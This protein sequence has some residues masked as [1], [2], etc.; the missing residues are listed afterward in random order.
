MS[1]EL[2]E[3]KILS[4][5]IKYADK[6][7]AELAEEIQQPILVEGPQGPVGP[8]GPKGEKGDTGPERR[9]VIEARGPVGPK[10]E[11][12]A[13]F[14]KALLED[15][16]LQLIREDGE[17]FVVGS[18]VGPRGGQGIPGVKGD[19]GDTGPRGE[20]GLIGEQGPV[21]AVGP[22]GDKGD[23]G[24]RGLQGERGFLGPQGP[25]GERGLIGEQGEPGPI[26]PQGIQGPKGDKGDKG[27]P[28]ATGPMGPQ[29]VP[30]RDGTEVDTESIRKSIEDNYQS[31]RDQIRQQVTRLATSGGGS[32]GGGIGPRPKETL[33]T[34]DILPQANDTYNLGG[35]GAYWKD[36]Y[37]SGNTLTL[38]AS[39]I[40][41]NNGTVSFG[42]ISAQTAPAGTSNTYV[43]TTEF[44]QV[45][46]GNLVNTAPTT[47]NTLKELADSLGNN[48]DFIGTVNINL[49]SKASN[50]Y[51]N[52][53]LSNTNSYI[54]TKLDS[55]SYTTADVQAKAALA[56][57]NA[58][59]DTKT[60]ESTSL[61]RLSN[62]NSYIATKIGNVVED[63]TPQLGGSLDVNGN[64]IVSVSNGDI[65]IE[66]NGTGNVLLGNL[67]FDAD[68]TVGAGQDNYVLTYDDA[69]GTIGLEAAAGGGG[70]GWEY[71]STITASNSSTIDFFGVFSS[72]YDYKITGQEIRGQYSNTYYYARLEMNNTGS[73]FTSSVYALGNIRTISGVTYG[74]TSSG[75]TL[76]EL[77]DGNPQGVSSASQ[78]CNFDLEIINP[79]DQANYFA[80]IRYVVWGRASNNTNFGQYGHHFLDYKNNLPITGIRFFFNN[81]YTS[82]GRFKLY[83]R[84]NV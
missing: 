84:A 75:S 50:T 41:D 30:G 42:S 5:A 21:G 32:S 17:V 52:Q 14:K 63:T 38:G 20:R 7:I 4:A 60:D 8:Q 57:T 16:K 76:F 59:I 47:L 74:R 12:G 58:Y 33:Y 26:G 6:K 62:T 24:E 23:Q 55:S 3:A 29:G 71:V 9:I 13:T 44:V 19:R 65:D 25:Q 39:T 53:L 15:G 81:G 64:K 34:R 69:V 54:G 11:P 79:A 68:Q 72:G 70:G 77:T 31:F 37:L 80:P 73:Q 82:K 66:P 36:L 46:I 27:D 43:A 78:H 83:R 56:N 51:V 28:G 2:R 40:S 67:T 45:A 35:P 10:G 49:A 48:A 61:L 22:K 1:N 18:V